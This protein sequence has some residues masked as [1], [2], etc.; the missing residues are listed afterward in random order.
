[1]NYSVIFTRAV[2][3]CLSVDIKEINITDK[4]K[5]MEIAV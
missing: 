1:M 2:E 5:V 3:G 4:D